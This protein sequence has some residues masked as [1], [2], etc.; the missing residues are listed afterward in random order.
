M[1]GRKER[2]YGVAYGADN[3]N[4]AKQTIHLAYNQW[5]SIFNKTDDNILRFINQVINKEYKIEP[6]YKFN[7]DETSIRHWE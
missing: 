2:L 7:D 6:C 1:L 3:I 5:M 4:F